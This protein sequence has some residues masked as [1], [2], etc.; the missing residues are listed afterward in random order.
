M[1]RRRGSK[2]SE[3]DRSIGDL[4]CLVNSRYGIFVLVRPISYLT[5]LPPTNM[6]W[7]YVDQG[8]QAGP[9]SDEQL[10]EMF[11][12]GTL[13]P[14]TL[15]WREGMADWTTYS[16]AKGGAATAEATGPTAGMKPEAVCAEC[17]K[18]FPMDEMIRYGD[19]RV[20]ATSKPVFLQK[21][22]EGAALT[23]GGLNY[24]S[25]GSRFLAILLDGVILF[26]FNMGVNL[27]MGLTMSQALG[28][29]PKGSLVI[30]LVLFAIQ[31]SVGIGY[32]ALM[33][34][35][36]GA[37]LGKMALKIKVVTADGGRVTYPRA[38]GRYFAK[39]LSNFTCLIG[40]I[41][42]AFDKPQRRA[43]HDYICN[44]RVIYK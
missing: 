37:T 2:I 34:G 31:L 21:L 13:R 3:K 5:P 26:A 24:A 18:M 4:F 23:T 20:C 29:A 28:M 14:D 27:I 40:F 38:F 22:Q 17:G 12:A 25:F 11:R 33:V 30:Q 1:H 15:V 41:I 43:L 36:Y 10:D 8:K 44:T 19:Q 7:F 6:N 16:E 39:L 9:V 42:A 32:E 35:K